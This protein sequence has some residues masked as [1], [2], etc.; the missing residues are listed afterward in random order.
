MEA[1]LKI[2]AAY[3]NAFMYEMRAGCLARMKYI[4]LVIG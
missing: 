4:K 1:E 3:D 2:V